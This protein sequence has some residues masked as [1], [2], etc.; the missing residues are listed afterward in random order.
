MGIVIS[1]SSIVL[2]LSIVTERKEKRREKSFVFVYSLLVTKLTNFS[3]Q[4]LLGNQSVG[5]S[6]DD[7]EEYS[8]SEETATSGYAS[9]TRRGFRRKKPNRRDWEHEEDW[10]LPMDYL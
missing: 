5:T 7:V 8:V 4:G 6:V 10:E 9:R 1:S 2:P 3:H